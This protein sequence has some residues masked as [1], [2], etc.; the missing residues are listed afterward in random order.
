MSGAPVGYSGRALPD[1]LGVKP[2]MTVVLAGAP[3]GFALTGVPT[4]RRLGGSADLVLA[5]F[6]ERRALERRWPA[7]TAAAGPA[8]AVWVAWPKRASGVPTDLTDNVIREV[9]LPTGWVDTKVCAVDETW[10]GLKCV[11]RVALRPRR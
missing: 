10:S 2:G 7:L 11:L 4:R 8:G 1:K 9:V 3:A 5:F 6:T